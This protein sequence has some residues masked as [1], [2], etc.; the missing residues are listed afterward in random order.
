MKR[1]QPAL[2]EFQWLRVVLDEAHCIKNHMTLASKVAC[3]LN[4]VHRWAC[5]GT[6]IQNGLDDIYGLMKFLGHE[7]WCWPSFWKTAVVKP[8]NA[9]REEVGS[10]E[11]SSALAALRNSTIVLD[12]VRKLLA[13]LMIRRTKDDVGINLPP[14]DTQVIEIDFD[15][16]ERQFYDA[17][18]QRS[19]EIFDDFVVS[20]T[21]ER[22]YLKI[23]SM[24]SRLRQ[25]CNHMSL[26]VRSR[27]DDDIGD[28]TGVKHEAEPSKKARKKPS[29]DDVGSVLGNGFLEDL[30]NKIS[31]SPRKKRAD[32]AFESPS[33]RAK[34]DT[35]LLRTA[36]GFADSIG[37]D[38]RHVNEECPICLEAPLIEKAAFSSCGHIFCKDC[39]VGY[40]QKRADPVDENSTL[41]KLVQVPNGECPCCKKVIQAH[42]IVTFAKSDLGDEAPTYACA[43][44][45]DTRRAAAVSV[46]QEVRETHEGNQSAIARQILEEAVEG[47]EKGSSKLSA[48]MEELFKV[49]ALDPGSKTL[50]FSHYLGFLDMLAEKLT[51]EGV[52]FYRFDGSL[53]PRDR[54]AVL[55]QFVSCKAS[56]AAIPGDGKLVKGAVL[57]MSMTAGAE[58]LNLTAASSCFIVEPWWNSAKEDQVSTMCGS[59]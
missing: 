21:A 44:L 8:W 3:D 32:D 28:M 16:P 20:G 5:T 33:K 37:Q 24:I 30:L 27:V 17:I 12:R 42:K 31:S 34:H 56:E 58:G 45:S 10:T 36:Q 53:T 50:I 25:T 47:I 23:L 40:L 29:G 7:P 57:L 9:G 14:V 35:Y 13:P 49:W 26:T 54:F 55:D 18:L 38:A 2:L 1:K 11:A 48:V 46:K 52:P 15:E 59:S 41:R 22:S 19:N 4:V 43:Y 51:S 6:I 39:L